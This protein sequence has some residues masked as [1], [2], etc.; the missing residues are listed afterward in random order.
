M[1]AANHAKHHVSKL[2]HGLV[3]SM[4]DCEVHHIACE[5]NFVSKHNS[6]KIMIAR[7]DEN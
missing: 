3:V 7:N 1:A 2:L 4:K 6:I 5:Q